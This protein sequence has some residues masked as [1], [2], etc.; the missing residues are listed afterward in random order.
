MKGKWSSPMPVPCSDRESGTVMVPARNG[1]KINT[2]IESSIRRPGTD[3]GLAIKY[4][5]AIDK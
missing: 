5:D 2:A 4:P 1:R 3:S